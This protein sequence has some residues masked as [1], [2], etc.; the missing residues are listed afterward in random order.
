MDPKCSCENGGSYTCA[1]SCKCQSCQCAPSKKSCCSCCPGECT[2]CARA[3]DGAS[4][5]YQSSI[6]GFHCCKGIDLN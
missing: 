5:S 3:V 2:K 6:T 1:G 4:I